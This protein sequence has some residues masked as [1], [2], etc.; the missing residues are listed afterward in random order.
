MEKREV[1]IASR[2]RR[3]YWAIP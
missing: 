2:Q 3:E 1:G